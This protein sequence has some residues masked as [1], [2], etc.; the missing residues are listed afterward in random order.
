MRHIDS[1]AAATDLGYEI[2]GVRRRPLVL[3]SSDSDS[4][5]PF[6]PVVVHREL[7]DAA[8]VVTIETGEATFALERVLP[9]KTHVFGGAARSYPPDFGAAPEWWRS[10]LRFPGRHD[11]EDL[12]DDALSQVISLTEAREHDRRSWET[13]TVELVSGTTGNVARLENGTRVMVNADLLPAQIRLEDA[14]VVGAGVEGWLSGRDFSPEAADVDF[15]CFADGDVTLARVVKVTEHRVYLAL[16]PLAPEVVLRRRDVVA[17]ADAGENSDVHLSDVVSVGQTLRARVCRSGADVRLSLVDVDE[18]VQIVP[19]LSLVRGGTPWLREGEHDIAVPT[20]TVDF[21]SD[22]LVEE[23]R[24]APLQQSLSDVAP[25]GHLADEVRE[26]RAEIMELRSAFA[27][28][29]RELRAGTDLETLDR[30]RD[31]ATTLSA[32]LHRERAKHA[33]GARMIARLTQELREA[34]GAREP[35]DSS[36]SRTSR[37]HWPNAEAWIR[38]EVENAWALRVAASDKLRYP[39]REYRIGPRFGESIEALDAAQFAKAMRAVVDVATG[40]VAEIPSRDLHRLREGTGGDDPY[41][42]RADGAKCWRASIESNAP[43]ARR[44]HYWE[45]PGGVVELSRVVLHD[46]FSA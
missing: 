21:S 15:A 34:R 25:T 7:A 22:A 39:L 16:H 38:H 6:D 10:V 1:A 30:L 19:P 32:E 14:L 3:I 20:A 4:T 28:L 29:A 33:E 2:L 12:I 24:S 46:D 43:S 31:E 17:G 44:L 37:E 42:V 26:L 27:R 9:E 8:D 45:L 41:V 5:F 23:D 11:I 36:A 40:R 35:S 18:A 13:A